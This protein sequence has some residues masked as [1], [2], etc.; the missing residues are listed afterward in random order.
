MAN[1]LRANAYSRILADAKALYGVVLTEMTYAG[2]C[3]AI[4][5]GQGKCLGKESSRVTIWQVDVLGKPLVVLYNKR[6]GRIVKVLAQSNTHK[7][8][9]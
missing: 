4:R 7:L 2:L 1:R 9:S 6:N 5:N 8:A 3:A